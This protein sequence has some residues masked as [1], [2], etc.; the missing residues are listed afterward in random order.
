MPVAL[1]NFKTSPKR[2]RLRPFVVTEL[3]K[4]LGTVK[5]G[6]GFHDEILLAE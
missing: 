2:P 3:C 4:G 1:Q 5:P 6:N